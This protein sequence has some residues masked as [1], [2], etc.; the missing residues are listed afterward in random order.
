VEMEEHNN[1]KIRSSSI[2]VSVGSLFLCRRS[3]GRRNR[4]QPKGLSAEATT[5]M[6]KM[7]KNYSFG[8]RWLRRSDVILSQRVKDLIVPDACIRIMYMYHCIRVI[9]VLLLGLYPMPINR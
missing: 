1:T 6:R 4:L 9:N 8:P 5:D 2:I 3:S 7:P